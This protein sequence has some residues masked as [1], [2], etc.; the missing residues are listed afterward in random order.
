MQWINLPQYL[1]ISLILIILTILGLNHLCL[2]SL[3]SPANFQQLTMLGISYL[4]Y[5]GLT[6][7][8]YYFL[9]IISSADYLLFNSWTAFYL[10]ILNGLHLLIAS[11]LLYQQYFSLSSCQR[12]RQSLALHVGLFS[13]LTVTILLSPNLYANKISWFCP[14]ILFSIFNISQENVSEKTDNGLISLLI[15][16]VLSLIASFGIILTQLSLI[17]LIWEDM[18]RPWLIRRPLQQQI[19]SIQV[20][21]S[22]L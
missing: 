1:P 17:N 5:D 8:L 2:T 3:I 4:T 11:P 10:G 6:N 7:Y 12:L 14:T 13:L 21:F 18:L 16:A 22:F 20:S 19:G 9:D 15:T